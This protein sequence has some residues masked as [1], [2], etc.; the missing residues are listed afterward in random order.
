MSTETALIAIDMINILDV[1]TQDGVENMIKKIEK[2]ARENI[3]DIST[4]LGRD[5]LKSM[6][7]KV[8][9]SKTLLDNAGKE[10]IAEQKKVLKQFDESRKALRDG[11]DTL[12]IR[13]PS[14]LD[15]VGRRASRNTGRG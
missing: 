3:F 1:F 9:R 12:K 5:Q 15:Q 6:S 4:A 7:Y 11:L 14:T 10:R 13:Y 2:K 8:A